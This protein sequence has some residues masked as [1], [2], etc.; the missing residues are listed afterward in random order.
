IAAVTE[1]LGR[2][3]VRS[4]ALYNFTMDGLPRIAEMIRQLLPDQAPVTVPAAAK[5]QQRGTRT[6]YAGVAPRL[7]LPL[8]AR[9]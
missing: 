4:H 6:K 1:E 9:V 7:P 5:P 8:A 3:N 2:D